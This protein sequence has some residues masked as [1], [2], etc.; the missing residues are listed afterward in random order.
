MTINFK[1]NDEDISINVNSN[2]PLSYTIRSQSGDVN[3]YASC[4][5]HTCGHCVVYDRNTNEIL[6]SCLTPAFHLEG[7]DIITSDYFFASKKAGYIKLAYKDVHTFPCSECI[8][9][10]TLVLDWITSILE[11][12]M[13]YIKDEKDSIF[14]LHLEEEH[15]MKVQDADNIVEQNKAFILSSMSVVKCTCLTPSDILA[16]TKA[17]IIRRRRS[18]V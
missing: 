4:T 11:K 7:A 18:N 1:L 17:A 14:F 8:Q 15:S 12:K 5:E 13:V 9:K 10:T 2:E 6:L 16:I 3:R